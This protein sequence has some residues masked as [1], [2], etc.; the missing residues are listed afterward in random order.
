MSVAGFWSDL[1]ESVGSMS[2]WKTAERSRP[3]WLEHRTSYSLLGQ[4]GAKCSWPSMAIFEDKYCV[5]MSMAI[6]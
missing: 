1:F 2:S 5:M 6:A 4:P 3:H